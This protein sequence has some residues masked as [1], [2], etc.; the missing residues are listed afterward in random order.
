MSYFADQYKQ[1]CPGVWVWENFLSAKELIPIMEEIKS[2][3]WVNNNHIFG[4]KSFAQYKQRIIDSLNS[5][6]IEMPDL[7]SCIRRRI[8]EGMEPHVDIQNHANTLYYNVV[9]KDSDIEK[10]KTKFARFGAVVYFN[11]DYE[12]GDIEYP[13]YDYVYKP[14]AGDL[15]LH[16][17]TNVH[18]VLRVKSDALRFTHSTYITDSEWVAKKAYEAIDW[19]DDDKFTL[20]DPRFWYSLS[21]GPSVNPALAKIQKTEVDM[22]KYWQYHP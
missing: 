7:D 20:K 13:E 12:G 14:K 9:D 18:A 8:G 11:D 4:F 15:V 21:H 1:L 17:A 10:I 2:K 19:P 22:T 5:P 16:K 3:D 6:D